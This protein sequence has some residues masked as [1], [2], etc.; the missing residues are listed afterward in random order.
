MVVCQ[1]EGQMN[2][3]DFLKPVETTKPSFSWDKDINIIH[4][5]ICNLAEKFN[6]PVK[7]AEWDVWNHVP[8]FGYRMSI[9]LDLKHSDIE[10]GELWIELDDI[11]TYGKQKNIEVYPMSPIFLGN[12]RDGWMHIFSTFMDKERRKIKKKGEITES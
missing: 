6:I 11:V 8:Q 10:N 2:I 1:L 9:T 4:E 5:K 7:R 3:F 12:D